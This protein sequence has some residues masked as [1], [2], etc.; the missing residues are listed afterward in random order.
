[1]YFKKS[2]SS[3]SR[4]ISIYHTLV[5][6]PQNTMFNDLV[7]QAQEHTLKPGL[8]MPKPFSKCSG[9]TFSTIFW[10]IR[11]WKSIPCIFFS[12]KL[13]EI[14][15][16]GIS[17]TQLLKATWQLFKSVL[18]SPFEHKQEK[19]KSSRKKEGS[20]KR[21]PQKETSRLISSYPSR[22]HIRCQSSAFLSLK[23]RNDQ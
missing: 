16:P 7:A 2:G 17:E 13:L 10:Q 8:P 3:T 14:R 22:K 15:C 23:C 21:E 11:L 6:F 20:K 18:L 19:K 1:M 4:W 9:A 5:Y 12:I